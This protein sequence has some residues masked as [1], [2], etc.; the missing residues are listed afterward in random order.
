[1][2]YIYS[3]NNLIAK[4]IKKKKKNSK[5]AD[6]TQRSQSY[7]HETSLSAGNKKLITTTYKYSIACHVKVTSNFLLRL[8]HKSLGI[9]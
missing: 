4:Q 3:P 6:T 8:A 2:L 1:M 5:N 7:D 9:G